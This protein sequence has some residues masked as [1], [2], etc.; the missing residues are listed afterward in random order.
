[1]KYEHNFYCTRDRLL[2][3]EFLF[4]DLGQEIGWRTYVLTHI[5]YKQFS[6]NRS[7]AH[8]NVYR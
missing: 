1:M 8:T 7:D 5:N 6:K 4:L 3:I 2:D